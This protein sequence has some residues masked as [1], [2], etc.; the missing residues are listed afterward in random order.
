MAVTEEEEHQIFW[1]LAPFLIGSCVDFLLQGYLFSQFFHYFTY[2]KDDKLRLRII[3]AILLIGTTLK[4]MQ[5][6]L[7][8]W[9][10]NI[11]HF[12]DVDGAVLLS[13]TSWWQ[14]GSGLMTASI[15]LYVQTYFLFRLYAI[16]QHFFFV[17]PI[18]IVLVFAYIGSIM[19]TYYSALAKQSGIGLWFALH[20]SSGDTLLCGATAYALL[21][22]T[23]RNSLKQT[24][25][26]IRRL[27][28]LTWQTMTPAA[29][30]ALCNL[31]FS[32]VYG[33]ESKLVSAAFNMA[34]PKLYA[35]S[36]MWTL[37]ARRAI[38]YGSSSGNMSSGEIS[39]GRSRR[40]EDV[41]LG[42]F[43]TV[44]TIHIRT[45]V[46]TLHYL[47][48]TRSDPAFSGTKGR[49]SPTPSHRSEEADPEHLLANVSSLSVRVKI[50]MP[51]PQPLAS[52]IISGPN[53]DARAPSLYPR[54]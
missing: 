40:R 47:E 11:V 18:A 37:N 10:Q 1:L 50:R 53:S 35:I 24:T 42:R 29:I 46:E 19:A 4:T 22:S 6:F 43:G 45:D 30:C 12:A 38:R 48:E 44:G 39:A 52:C 9:Q 25:D 14:T 26:L 20:L 13:Y 5:A 8:I 51:S 21:T 31:I 54:A 3:V 15:G 23:G 28:Q 41:E 17:V 49:A 33:G 34:L 27:V 2:Y 16:T 36:M 7:V 32:Q